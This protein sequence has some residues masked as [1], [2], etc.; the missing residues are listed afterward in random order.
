M[1]ARGDLDWGIRYITHFPALLPHS[2]GRDSTD[3]PD[4]NMARM[5]A[6]LQ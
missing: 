1:K 6:I 5:E 3:Q 2:I 4:S